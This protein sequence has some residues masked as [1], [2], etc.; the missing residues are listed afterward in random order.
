MGMLSVRLVTLVC[1][2]NVVSVGHT[3][4]LALGWRSEARTVIELTPPPPRSSESCPCRT[5]RRSPGVYGSLLYESLQNCREMYVRFVEEQGVGPTLILFVPL[6]PIGDTPSTNGGN[7][8]SKRIPSI[9][10]GGHWRLHCSA[11]S[12]TSLGAKHYSSTCSGTRSG[13]G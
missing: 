5:H 3:E 4:I 9:T 1:R 8:G 7:W 10:D 6:R 13:A 11:V 2:L 12:G